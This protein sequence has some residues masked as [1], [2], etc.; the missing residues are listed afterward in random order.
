MFC[1]AIM[2]YTCAF[3]SF[4]NPPFSLF[5]FFIEKDLHEKNKNVIFSSTNSI[6]DLEKKLFSIYWVGFIL[7]TITLLTG[8]SFSEEL[9]GAAFKFN[10]K[11]VFSILAWLV[12]GALVLGRALFGLR[13]RKAIHL[14]LIGFVFLL[15]AYIGT[16]FVFEILLS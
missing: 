13:G 11:F 12:Y 2:S 8:I 1:S 3:N 7:L 9:F 16:K 14:S 10:H 4:I 15:L 5:L 6:L